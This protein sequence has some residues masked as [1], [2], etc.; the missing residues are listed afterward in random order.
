MAET[1]ELAV[2]G[3]KMNII[4][5]PKDLKGNMNTRKP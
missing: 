5:M 2:K 3:F 4:N 1:I